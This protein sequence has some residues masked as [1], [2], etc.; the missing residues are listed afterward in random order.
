SNP[1][2]KEKREI[3]LEVEGLEGS[4][5][6]FKLFLSLDDTL[7]YM[8]FKISADDPGKGILYHATG[9]GQGLKF[10]L[11]GRGE[12]SDLNGK[13]HV[14]GKDIGTVSSDI[15]VRYLED[16]HIRLSG[17]YLPEG[18]PWIEKYSAGP[19]M[20][21]DFRVDAGINRNREIH[22]DYL[23]VKSGENEA[24]FK[25]EINLSYLDSEGNFNISI[26]DPLFLSNVLK[27]Y[28]LNRLSANGSIKGR[29]YSPDIDLSLNAKGPGNE[30]FSISE[31]NGDAFV[32]FPG[33]SRD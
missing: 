27:G 8:T 31:I 17:D 23:Q 4:P 28:T 18:A 21:A 20:R 11:E 14:S 15:N 22:L 24:M 1:D 19:D 10:D 32:R 7:R 9:F 2:N 13:L 26:N 30:K 33:R 6:S 16:V 3:R 5:G 25:G 29:L 12:L